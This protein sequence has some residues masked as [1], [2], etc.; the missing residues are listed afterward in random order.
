MPIPIG[1]VHVM[2]SSN[3][4]CQRHQITI[5]T[6]TSENLYE[7]YCFER[8]RK[9]PTMIDCSQIL[10]VCQDISFNNINVKR[11]SKSNRHYMSLTVIL[12]KLSH[13][14]AFLTIIKK[15]VKSHG[16]NS[17]RNGKANQSSLIYK[18]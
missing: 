18:S 12:H 16:P 3:M 4:H 15:K 10:T 7:Y 9:P 5:Y 2:F 13:S 1:L 17:Q 6:I 11:C 14:R 8:R